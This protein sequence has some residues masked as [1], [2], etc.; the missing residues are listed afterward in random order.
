MA[1]SQ[2]ELISKFDL[3]GGELAYLWILQRRSISNIL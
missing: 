1:S 2:G 3:N